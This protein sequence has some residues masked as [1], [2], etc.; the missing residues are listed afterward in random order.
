MNNFKG[1]VERIATEAVE[2]WRAGKEWSD[3][4]M[5]L[6]TYADCGEPKSVWLM[7][8]VAERVAGMIRD[9]EA[10]PLAGRTMSLEESLVSLDLL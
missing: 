8:A 9:G 4:L 10:G 2:R 3:E 7:A 1:R 5:M 6:D